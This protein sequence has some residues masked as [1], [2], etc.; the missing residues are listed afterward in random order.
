[1]L[2]I[3]V[4]IALVHALADYGHYVQPFLSDARGWT[5]GDG[6][7]QYAEMSIFYAEEYDINA[8]KAAVA[9][10]AIDRT[11]SSDIE[12]VSFS[13][14]MD[15][16]T[17]IYLYF[18]PVSGYTGGFT[19]DGYTATKQSDGRYLVKIPNIGADK[20]GTTY[21]V[22]ATTDAGST[23]VKVSALSYVKGVLDAYT[24]DS[25]KDVHAQNAAAAIYRYYAAANAYKQVHP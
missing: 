22:V 9:D 5:V 12:K 15:T 3:N 16:D 2:Q 24:T 17:S 19:V 14:L 21:T 1:M 11:Y 7:D 4:T 13:L 10:Y 6:N 25:E 18:K 23:T 8:V 20:L